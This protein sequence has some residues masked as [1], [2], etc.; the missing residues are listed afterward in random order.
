MTFLDE[1]ISSNV[2]IFYKCNQTLRKSQTCNICFLKNIEIRRHKKKYC[3]NNEG[4]N[5]PKKTSLRQINK[6]H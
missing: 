2:I 4:D 5:F 3:K 1:F 6:H